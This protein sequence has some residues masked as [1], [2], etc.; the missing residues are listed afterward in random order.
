MYV[1]HRF[2]LVQMSAVHPSEVLGR[3]DPHICLMDGK[4]SC[5]PSQYELEG[6]CSDNYGGHFTPRYEYLKDVSR[7]RQRR[8]KVDAEDM[9]NRVDEVRL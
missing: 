9:Q 5:R 2:Y 4:S 1:L 8:Y 3:S 6:N 7:V